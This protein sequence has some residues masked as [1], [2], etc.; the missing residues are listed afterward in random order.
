MPNSSVPEERVVAIKIKADRSV[1]VG[2]SWSPEVA[3]FYMELYPDLLEYGFSL[4]E[5]SM[6]GQGAFWE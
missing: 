5:I 4:Q 3:D 1:R 6:L 2:L